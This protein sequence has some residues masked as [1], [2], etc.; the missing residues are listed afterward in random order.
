M[1]YSLFDTRRNGTIVGEGAGIVCLESLES[2]EARGAIP[3]REIAGWGLTTGTR[4][5]TIGR[6]TQ[7]GRLSP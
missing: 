2:A 4:G 1:G 5:S 3:D 7:P 6:R